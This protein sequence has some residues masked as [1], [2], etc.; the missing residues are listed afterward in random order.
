DYGFPAD[1]QKWL[2]RARHGLY[3]DFSYNIP[4]ENGS[5][6]INLYFVELTGW[7]KGW[8]VFDVLVNGKTAIAKLDIL[9]EVARL[10]PLV[11]TI[12]VTV[13]QGKIQIATKRVNRFGILSAIEILPA[14]PVSDPKTPTISLAP[15]TL[16]LEPGGVASVT[17]TLTDASASDIVWT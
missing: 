16:N 6:N 4:V 10:K 17:P 7:A 1:T 3:R 12:P 5:Y 8:R 9:A 13:T 15:A 14:D 2:G 11:K